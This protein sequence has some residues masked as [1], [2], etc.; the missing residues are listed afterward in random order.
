MRRSFRSCFVGENSELAMWRHETY[1]DAFQKALV[2]GDPSPNVLAD[3]I[4]D[5]AGSDMDIDDD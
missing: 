4:D 5:G 2:G 1:D 3:I